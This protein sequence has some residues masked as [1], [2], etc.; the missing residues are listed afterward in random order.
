MPNVEL[1]VSQAVISLFSEITESLNLWH[2]L[3]KFNQI[4]EQSQNSEEKTIV[5]FS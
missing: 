5:W 2:I 3:Q 1:I 4:A